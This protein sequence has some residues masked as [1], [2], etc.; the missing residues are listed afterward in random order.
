M[1]RTFHGREPLYGARVGKAEGADCAARPRLARGPLDGVKTVAPFVA[2]GVELTVRVVAPAHILDDDGVAA[3]DGPREC[4]VSLLRAVFAVRR[5]VNEHGITR[6]TSRPQDVRAKDDSVA[7]GHSD[8]ALNDCRFLRRW[9]RGAGVEAAQRR[10]RPSE[11]YIEKGSIAHEV[12]AYHLPR[13]ANKT[14]QN[15]VAGEVDF[16]GAY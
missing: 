12:R 4:L 11:S 16:R 10:R 1:G 3:R 13:G 9:H 15:V 6:L 7:H 14:M 8:V 5:A 2:V